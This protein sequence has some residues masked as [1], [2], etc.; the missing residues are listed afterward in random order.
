MISK[1]NIYFVCPDE[2]K[3]SGGVKQIYRQ[4]DILNK[5]GYHASVL[6]GKKG[7][8]ANWF[9]H[10][11]HII[12][13]PYLHYYLKSQK[14]QNQKKKPAAFFFKI[15]G[16]VIR[17]FSPKIE[18]NALLVFP[19]IYGPNVHL[20][21]RQVEK[22]IF[23]QNCY[24]TFNQFPDQT[25]LS[26]SIY[27]HI[28]HCIVVSEDSQN[29]MQTAFPHLSVH[30]IKLGINH[31]VFHYTSQKKLQ[32]AYMPRKRSSEVKQIITILK[33]RKKIT[34]WE[35]IAIDGV[36]EKQVAE[37][38]KNSS[39][40]LSFN[41]IEGFGLPPAEAM[42][43]G[44]IVIGYPGNAGKEYFKPEFSFPIEENN[45]IDY[46]LKI[47]EVCLKLEKNPKWLEEIGQKAAEYVNENYS[48]NHEEKSILEVWTKILDENT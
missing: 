33:N 38:L 3:N 25:L 5:N 24:Y 45:I 41:H 39:I 42:S 13:R 20:I 12:Y 30:R 1:R 10:S 22:I 8:K 23:N 43:C 27:D 6:H 16:D 31:E 18:K 34:G 15:L 35:L 29:Y 37:I 48:M 14:K 19:E 44:N 4:V 46:V 26:G 7:F 11:T 47:E 21:E 36:K 32:V 40:F 28:K 2:K 17:F 9:A